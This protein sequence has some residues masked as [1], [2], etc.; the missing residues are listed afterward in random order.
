MIL[1]ALQLDPAAVCLHRPAGDGQSQTGA[2]GRLFAFSPEPRLP[3][4]GVKC[5]PVI[6]P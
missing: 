4:A 6:T 2:A 1:F 5:P 3:P